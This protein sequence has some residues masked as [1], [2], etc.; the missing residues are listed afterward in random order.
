MSS[1]RLRLASV[2]YR[3]CSSARRMLILLFTSLYCRTDA[4]SGKFC[5]AI[6]RSHCF[7]I[8]RPSWRHTSVDRTP[9]PNV[10]PVCSSQCKDVGAKRLFPPGRDCQL[11]ITKIPIIG[12]A[13]TGLPLMSARWMYGLASSSVESSSLFFFFLM[14]FRWRI[15]M[16]VIDSSFLHF[17]RFPV[18]SYSSRVWI[19]KMRSFLVTCYDLF[20]LRLP[21]AVWCRLKAPPEYG[22]STLS[23]SFRSCTYRPF[24]N[25]CVASTQVLG[26]NSND[27]PQNAVFSLLVDAW[28]CPAKNFSRRLR[29]IVLFSMGFILFF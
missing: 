10:C 4:A 22:M 9:S 12:M 24:R 25:H 2:W 27:I 7:S 11:P 26:E 28:R 5:R 16:G 14:F 1:F 23:E 13:F 3:L 21:P 19:F 17:R 18:F 8:G 29:V 6:A 20:L 15:D